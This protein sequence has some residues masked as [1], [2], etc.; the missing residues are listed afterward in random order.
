MVVNFKY[1]RPSTK[2]LGDGVVDW[3]EPQHEVVTGVEE[4]SK[5]FNILNKEKV[6]WD[7]EIKIGKD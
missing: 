4:A 1:K 5:V 3:R 6:V 2:T 7:L